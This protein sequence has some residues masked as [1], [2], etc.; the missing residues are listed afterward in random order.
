MSHQPTVSGCSG[1]GDL[2][3]SLLL[4]L[5]LRSAVHGESITRKPTVLRPCRCTTNLLTVLRTYVNNWRR[6]LQ[7]RSCLACHALAGPLGIAVRQRREQMSSFRAA[8]RLFGF[9][10]HPKAAASPPRPWRWELWRNVESLLLLQMC[11]PT[12]C[13]KPYGF[14]IQL[15]ALKNTTCEGKAQSFL[16]KEK[17]GFVRE[18]KIILL[19]RPSTLFPTSFSLQRFPRVILG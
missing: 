2:A 19:F 14:R 6:G 5:L 3:K 7:V 8:L 10:S 11:T 12:P 15:G 9:V 16:R 17:A 18:G 4:S 13:A 1:W